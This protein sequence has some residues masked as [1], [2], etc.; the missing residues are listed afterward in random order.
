MKY[1][2]KSVLLVIA[3]LVAALT[4]CSRR[5]DVFESRLDVLGTFAQVSI[6]G[7]TP[8][9]AGEATRH[10]EEVLTSLDHIGYTFGT[11]GELKRMNEALAKGRTIAVSDEMIEL[12][13]KSRQLSL[14]SGGLFNPAAGELTALWEFHCDREACDTPPPYP[15]EVQALVEEKLAREL[16]HAPTMED[17]VV[18]GHRVSTRNRHVRL[19]FGD[20]IRGLALDL[21]IRSLRQAGADDAMIDIG[22]SVHTTGMRGDHAWWIGIP[23]ATGRHLIG[24]IETTDNESVVT[25]R[26]LDTS[27]GKEDLVYRRIVD[28]RTGKPVHEIRSVTVAHNSAMVANAAATAFIIAGTR[29]WKHVADR[30][31]VH[32][33]LLITQDG[34]IYTSPAIDHRIHWKQGITHQHL[35]P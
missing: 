17:I 31:D 32:A 13:E 26:A 35:V 34:T 28:P 9:Q 21:G 25:V 12:L 11:S 16:E 19:E 33:L 29:D 1:R 24:S 3:A 22:G 10:A 4:G 18:R 27:F 7:L 30:M 14:A 5:T 23:D 20:I 8:E 6:A 15:D 2:I